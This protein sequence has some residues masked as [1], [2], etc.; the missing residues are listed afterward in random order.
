MDAFKL[1]SQFLLDLY[2]GAGEQPA[3]QF[4]DWALQRLARD[5]PFDSAFWASAAATPAGLVGHT[6]H[7]YH[8]PA[9]RK[10]VV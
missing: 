8:Q 6:L 3:E 4:Q 9:D 7:L 2:R 1:Q 5:L 10:S